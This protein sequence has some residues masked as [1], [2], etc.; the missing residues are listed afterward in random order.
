MR[1][2][3]VK[4]KLRQGKVAFGT[5]VGLADP[6]LIEIIGLAGFDAAFIDTE[7]SAFDHHLVAEMV[8]IA[9]LIGITAL[10]RVPENNPKVILRYLDMGAHGIQVPHVKDK[11]GA[12][13]AVK[14][15]RYAPLGERGVAGS[16]RATRYGA[17]PLQEHIRTSNTEILLAVMIEDVEALDNIEAIA[18]VDG[19]DLLAIGPSD[20]SQSLGVTDGQDPK[21]R[22]VVEKIA[23]AVRKVGKAKMSIS[24]GHASF[25]LKPAQLKEMGVGYANCGPPDV[26]RLLNAY[27]QQVQDIQSQ[28]S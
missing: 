24:L 18:A 7:H 2:N 17:I 11:E 9:D 13:A 19:V 14:A 15:I 8:R 1:E 3:R 10:V 23:A 26:L 28:I 20:L 25:P 4:A 22:G 27:R 21:I 16:T 6:A 12:I 5:Y